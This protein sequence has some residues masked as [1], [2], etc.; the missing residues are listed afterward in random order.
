MYFAQLDKKDGTCMLC[1]V[2][3][4]IVIDEDI[5]FHSE[6]EEEVKNFCESWNAKVSSNKKECIMNKVEYYIKCS[7]DSLE[8]AMNIIECSDDLN[9]GQ[10]K[11]VSDLYKK[12]SDAVKI[13]EDI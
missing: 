11:E 7:I 2:A 5:K 4:E 10:N 9:E 12:I 6:D 13:L 3:E 1:C 8:I